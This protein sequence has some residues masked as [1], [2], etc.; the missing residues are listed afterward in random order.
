V[1]IFILKIAEYNSGYVLSRVSG[2][3]SI[4]SK[5]DLA[6]EIGFRNLYQTIT[7]DNRNDDYVSFLVSVDVEAYAAAAKLVRGGLLPWP[8][9]LILDK[10]LEPRL[11][12][13]TEAEVDKLAVAF[14]SQNAVMN[15]VYKDIVGTW[16]KRAEDEGISLGNFLTT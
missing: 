1:V 6:N 9:V 7:R 5:Y 15:Q 11:V 14:D 3:G 12:K 2:L 4:N 13:A 8:Y 16:K 10:G